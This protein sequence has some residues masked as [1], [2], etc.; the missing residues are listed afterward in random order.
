MGQIKNIK[1]HIVTDIKMMVDWKQLSL[2]KINYEEAENLFKVVEKNR[3]Y[4]GRWV[5]IADKVQ[6]CED[7]FTLI[8]QRIRSNFPCY[9]ICYNENIIGI[10]R[11]RVCVHEDTKL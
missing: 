11:I 9:F 2:S 10:V 6:T 3:T 4:L 5:H 1:L 8:E 7:S